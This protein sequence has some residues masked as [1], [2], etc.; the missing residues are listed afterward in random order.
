M[1]DSRKITCDVFELEVSLKRGQWPSLSYVYWTDLPAGTQVGLL[2]FRR[3]EDFSD[4]ECSWLLRGEGVV[5][6]SNARGDFNGG[7]DTIDIREADRRALADFE[8]LLRPR[9]PGMKTPPSDE[10]TLLLTVGGRQRL[11]AFGGGNR[12]LVGDM[13]EDANGVNIVRAEVRAVCPM[14]DDTNPYQPPLT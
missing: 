12:N 4:Q 7:L 14:A 2:C 6:G 8:R 11:K 9:A 10:I 13:V 3:Y 5:V 1:G